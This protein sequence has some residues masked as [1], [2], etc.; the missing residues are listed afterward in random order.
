MGLSRSRQL[1]DEV[2]VI[3]VGGGGASRGDAEFGEDV[4]D[5]AG[6]GL[7]ADDEFLRDSP[8]GLAS[9]EEEQDLQFALGETV[10]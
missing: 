4:A 6:D 3:G 1:F 8:V 10:W 2:V 5:V 7:F 9:G